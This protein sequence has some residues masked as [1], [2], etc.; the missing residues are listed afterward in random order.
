[1]TDQR[2]PL[3]WPQPAHRHC[4]QLSGIRRLCSL[5]HAVSLSL[6]KRIGIVL[7][8]ISVNGRKSI[9]RYRL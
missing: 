4:N 6:I 5:S 7:V 8:W 2:R 1:M 3:P 9:Y